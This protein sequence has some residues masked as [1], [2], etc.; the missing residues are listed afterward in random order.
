L[1]IFG[2][3][4]TQSLGP[5]SDIDLLILSDDLPVPAYDR[6][7]WV[8]PL[9]SKWREV[10]KAEFPNFPRVLS[11]LMISSSGFGAS[12]GLRLSLSQNAWIL[13]DDGYLSSLLSESNQWI[14]SGKWE[15]RNLAHGGWV[16]IPKEEVA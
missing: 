16:W 5:D 14:Q 2:S 1:A 6:S 13:W 7:C 4:V 3:F 10:Q 12:T 15:R 8:R 11:P 9:I